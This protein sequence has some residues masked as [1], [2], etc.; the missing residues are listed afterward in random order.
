VDARDGVKTQGEGVEH[1]SEF[2]VI[3]LGGLEIDGPRQRLGWDGSTTPLAPREMSAMLALAAEAGD[4]VPAADLARR[5]WPGSRMVT[6]YDVR[7]IIYRLRQSLRASHIPA[8]IE[9]VRG[10]GY[11]L[12]LHP[13]RDV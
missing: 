9:N 13:R 11:F 2:S 1:L 6:A 5:I 7:R 10:R 4:P 8:S 12:D 3:E